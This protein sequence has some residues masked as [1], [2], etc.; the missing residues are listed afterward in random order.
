MRIIAFILIQI[1]FHVTNIHSL[2]AQV[3]GIRHESIFYSNRDELKIIINLNDEEYV[4]AHS[5]FTP[6]EYTSR[7]ESAF[8]SIYPIIVRTGHL[9]V[10]YGDQWRV[11]STQV[12]TSIQTNVLT[13]DHSDYPVNGGGSALVSELPNNYYLIT[14]I[15]Q[16]LMDNLQLFHPRFIL[17]K[18]QND[19]PNS[20]PWEVTTTFSP[21]P[22]NL[23]RAVSVNKISDKHFEIKMSDDTVVNLTFDGAS[24]SGKEYAHMFSDE[25]GSFITRWK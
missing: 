3:G 6:D 19:D 1:S 9:Y 17:L 23:R 25:L 12:F 21:N 10:Q 15:Y 13:I 11:A 14:Y 16:Q 18:Y 2:S 4:L 24:N 22:I 8:N 7:Y 20:L 5:D